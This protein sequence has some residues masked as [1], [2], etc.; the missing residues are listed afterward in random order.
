M[1][2]GRGSGSAAAEG[3]EQDSGSELE[4]EPAV[5]TPVG[6]SSIRSKCEFQNATMPQVLCA[7]ICVLLFRDRLIKLLKI[8]S[9]VIA[10][11]LLQSF[12]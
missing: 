10:A 3:S 6:R 1:E 7:H 9:P 12:S 5:E 2:P 11:V 8:N 4:L